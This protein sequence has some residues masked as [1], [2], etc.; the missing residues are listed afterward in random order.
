MLNGHEHNQ[1]IEPKRPAPDV[2]EIVLDPLAKRGSSTPAVNLG[3]AGHP[4][5]NGMAEFVIAHGMT[6]LFDED[7]ALGPGTDQAHIAPQDV[8][9]LGQFVEVGVP[10]PV[11]DAGASAVMIR[12]PDRPG[13]TLCITSHAPE[14]DD[15]KPP[16]PLSHPLLGIE[17]R[18]ARSQEDGPGNE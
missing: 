3:P 6:E 8:E 5:G 4:A 7:G 15:T 13:F 12:R 9:E 18:T 10:Q 17:D 16:T 1:E 2:V 11:A 14:L